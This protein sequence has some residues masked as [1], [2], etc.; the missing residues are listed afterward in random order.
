MSFA[1]RLRKLASE[2]AIYG[3]SSVVG[4][5]ITFILFPFYS[6]FF[7][8][9]EY[10]IVAVVF[11]LFIFANVV[12]QYGIESAYLKFANDESTAD[13]RKRVTSTA[14]WSLLATSLLFS[15]LL[16]AG[17]TQVASLIELADEWQHLLY[18]V[19]AI[20]VLDTVAVVPLAGLRLDNK[21]KQFAAIRIASILVNVGLNVYLIAFRRMGIEAVF[22][23]NVVSSAATLVMLLPRLATTTAIRFDGA[24][25]KAMLRFGLPFVPGGLGYAFAERVNI[26]FLNAMPPDRVAALYGGEI[27]AVTMA[28]LTTPESYGAY[29]A[30]VFNGVVKLAVVMA[31][32]VQM[33]RYAW[34]PF[35][36]QHA[37]DPDSRPLFARVFTLFT[38]LSLFVVLAVSFYAQEIVALPLPGGRN[39][40][41]QR[42]WLGLFV[43]PILLLGYMFQGMY[44]NVSAGAYIERK[45][46][47][48]VY[49]AIAGAIVAVGINAIFV[50]RFG[51][52]AAAWSA[53]SAYF[54]MASMLLVLVRRVYPVPY[55][56]R[57]IGALGLVALLVFVAWQEVDAL[58][59]PFA[60][61][62][63]LVAFVLVIFG[64]RIASIRAVRMLLRVNRRAT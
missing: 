20:L 9:D 54:V 17:K 51:M 16:L 19:A 43:V 41:E 56:W 8:P 64:M 22:I 36:L 29:V 15:A 25:W 26:F 5:L 13:G 11:T 49:C 47:Y 21:P 12:Y 31:L 58:R 6:Q 27:D 2:T 10:G 34:Q 14:I 24:T 60:E 23:A 35:F 39:L 57:R 1:A 37:R 62:G 52:I 44:Y 42:Y 30:G 61:F 38:A 40:V 59:N 63:L 55:D 46:G 28:S 53:T 32:V 3:I 50:P 45:T 48:F 33:F 7:A 18:Y 4:R